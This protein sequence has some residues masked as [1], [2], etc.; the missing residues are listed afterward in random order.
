M[1][2]LAWSGG[3]AKKNLNGTLH[4]IVVCPRF[5]LLYNSRGEVV[6]SKF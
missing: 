3:Q 5:L 1:A 2:C 6:V 4:E